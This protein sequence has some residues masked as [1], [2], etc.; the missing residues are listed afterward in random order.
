M[1]IANRALCSLVEG[2]MSQT[3]Q[4]L[5]CLDHKKH[6]EDI[7]FKKGGWVERDKELKER[8]GGR[9]RKKLRDCNQWDIIQP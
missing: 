7:Y 1:I 3:S 2:T 6:S 5:R 4:L 8:K 9:G